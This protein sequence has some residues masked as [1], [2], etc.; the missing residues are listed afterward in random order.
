MPDIVVEVDTQAATHLVQS[1][2]NDT[3]ALTVTK[4]P[5]LVD[6]AVFS[7]ASTSTSL[8]VDT[9]AHRTGVPVLIQVDTKTSVRKSLGLQVD[10]QVHNPVRE[11]VLVDSQV[12]IKKAV[13]VQVDTYAKT[14]TFKNV[15]VLVDTLI[16]QTLVSTPLVV[17][18]I[19][20]PAGTLFNPA[21]LSYHYPYP[22]IES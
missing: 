4:Q 3:Q 18:T 20:V 5:V 15:G 10:S 8:L 14:K 17:N 13:P 22:P 11:S 19:A 12:V 1:V 6:S 2:Q 7:G 16:S 21:I 9:K